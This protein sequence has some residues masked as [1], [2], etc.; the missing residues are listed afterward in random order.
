MGHTNLFRQDFVGDNGR[1]IANQI[2]YSERAA[3]ATPFT[4]AFG[5][6]RLSKQMHAIAQSISLKGVLGSN[7]QVF[8]ASTG[9]FDTHESQHNYLPDRH[10]EIDTA[11][12]AFRNAMI[13]IGEWDNVLVFTM[14]DF[15]RTAVGNGNGTDHGWGSH[16]FVLGGSIRGG[17]VHG[18]LPSPDLGDPQYTP[19]RGRL[20][21]TTAVEQYAA[22]IGQWF[23]LDSG[24]L[25]RVFPNLSRFDRDALA[26]T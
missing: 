7:R 2:E 20:I 19:D 3:N 9:G 18:D 17:I 12:T 21:P 10:T 15:G 24:E 25:A 23:G 4:T 13:E 5:N 26:I 14:S 16:Q 22:S 1:G 6:D 8:Y 11:L